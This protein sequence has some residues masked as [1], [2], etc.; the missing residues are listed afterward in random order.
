MRRLPSPKPAHSLGTNELDLCRLAVLPAFQKHHLQPWLPPELA[1]PSHQ[2]RFDPK[3]AD[4]ALQTIDSV[5][6]LSELE[7]QSQSTQRAPAIALQDRR[8]ILI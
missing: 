3:R 2:F 7:E 8:V 4:R 5:S 1:T 6:L